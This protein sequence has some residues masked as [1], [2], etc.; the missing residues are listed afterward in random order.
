MASIEPLQPAENIFETVS[1]IRLAR[2]LSSI[3]RKN[4]RLQREHPH[5]AADFRTTWSAKRRLDILAQ[6]SANGDLMT[7]VICSRTRNG[8]VHG[9]ANAQL[10]STPEIDDT[11]AA[12]ISYWH[13]PLAEGIAIQSGIEV[14]RRMAR[15]AIDYYGL[16]DADGAT[17]YVMSDDEIKHR[18]SH[19]VGLRPVIEQHAGS[20]PLSHRILYV[21]HIGVVAA[22]PVN[23]A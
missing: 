18:V 13:L 9:L 20:S 2:Q 14:V 1:Q 5:A 3:A 15:S 17:M 6:Q 21:G 4:S 10:H 16:Q 12:E 19:E 8:A 11:L 7:D 23:W 22:P